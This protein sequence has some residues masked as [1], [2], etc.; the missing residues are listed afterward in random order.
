MIENAIEQIAGIMNTFPDIKE[1]KISSK[2]R[3]TIFWGNQELQSETFTDSIDLLEWCE[4]NL[5]STLDD[6]KPKNFIT[7]LF[8]RLKKNRNKLEF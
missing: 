1:I 5:K 8:N 4:K 6:V 7:S 2:N 3:F